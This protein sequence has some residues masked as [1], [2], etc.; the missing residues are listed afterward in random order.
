MIPPSLLSVS[1]WFMAVPVWRLE[2]V[3]NAPPPPSQEATGDAA[4][5]GQGPAE[6]PLC[7]QKWVFQGIEWRPAFIWDC[8]PNPAWNPW[9]E[10]RDDAAQDRVRREDR[11]RH[12]PHVA[13]PKPAAAE[14][15]SLDGHAPRPD[16]QEG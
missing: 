3:V 13:P 7:S 14:P 2:P 12:D 15:P 4:A 5:V 1:G 6:S 16:P 9:V 10:A 8:L 11:L